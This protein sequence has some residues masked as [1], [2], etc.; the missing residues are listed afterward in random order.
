MYH[1]NSIGEIKLTL[2]VVRIALLHQ[3]VNIDKVTS[4]GFIQEQTASLED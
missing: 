2:A 1:D 4:L 3:E